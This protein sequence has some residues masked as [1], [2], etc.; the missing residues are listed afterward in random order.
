[1]VDINIGC[2]GDHEDEH[3]YRLFVTTF[4][5][6]GAN[7]A[8]ARHQRSLLYS[9][10]KN[11][12]SG[13]LRYILKEIYTIL[14][15]FLF[16]LNFSVK[17]QELNCFYLNF[18]D[19]IGLS[20]DKPQNDPCQPLGMKSEITLHIEFD[21]LSSDG[22][23]LFLKENLTV[24]SE[25]VILHTIGTGAWTDCYDSIRD[26][27]KES[28]PYLKECKLEK[29]G[30]GNCADNGIHLPSVLH[31]EQKEFYGFSEFWYSMEDVLDLGGKFINE[32]L[33]QEATVK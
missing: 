5:G 21:K 4:L 24:S 26:F 32:K 7:E 8:L 1:M 16:A 29:E 31:L 6:Y 11:K 14:R 30:S 18:S 22:M 10:I 13:E 9:Q 27:T 17:S 28:E 19:I 3:A 2:R 15:N 25:E 33:K 20:S 23:I 12:L